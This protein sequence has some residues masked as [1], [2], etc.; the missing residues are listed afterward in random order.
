MSQCYGWQRVAMFRMNGMSQCHGWQRVTMFR[1]NVDDLCSQH[2][3]STSIHGGNVTM[4]WMA[5]SDDVL[6]K[7][8]NRYIFYLV[9]S[10]VAFE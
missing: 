1:M 2:I 5:K 3:I 10:D 8:L 9:V 4:T 6:G 7:Q